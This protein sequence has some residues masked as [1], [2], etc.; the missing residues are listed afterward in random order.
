M[1]YQ[2]VKKRRNLNG[3]GPQGGTFGIFEYLSQSNK[4]ANCVEEN[5]KWKLVDDLTIL[6]I[7]NLI[8]IGM[9]SFNVRNQVSNDFNNDEHYILNENLETHA[10]I[11][12]IS[13]WTEKQKMMLNIKKTNYIIFYFTNNHQFNTRINIK[14]GNIEEKTKL[15]CWVQ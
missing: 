5:R 15:N 13:D 6:E 2:K 8:N 1:A 12:W 4:N 3:G 10:N 14:G 7:I 9:S 11:N